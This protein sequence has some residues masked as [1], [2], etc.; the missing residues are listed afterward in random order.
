MWGSSERVADYFF[1]GGTPHKKV[2]GAE[3][4]KGAMG[5]RWGADKA[6]PW[7]GA[8]PYSGVPIDALER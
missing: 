2:P 1:L 3:G 7:G 5:C 6:S 4:V 8:G